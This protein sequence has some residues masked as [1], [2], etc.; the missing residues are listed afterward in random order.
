MIERCTC[1]SHKSNVKYKHI[2]I[3]ERWLKSFENFLE[4]M[5]ERL[6]G[7]TLERVDNTKGYEASNCKWATYAEQARNRS[8]TVLNQEIVNEIVALYISGLRGTEISRRL[9]LNRSTVNNVIY[10]GDWSNKGD[11]NEQN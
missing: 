11:L 1:T 10:R 5:G 7:T 2:S 3:T 4:D 8:S 6:E 9:C